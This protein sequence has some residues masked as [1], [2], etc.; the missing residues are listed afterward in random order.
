MSCAFLNSIYVIYLKNY[1]MEWSALLKY[2]NILHLLISQQA[3]YKYLISRNQNAAL[4]D[5]SFVH[6]QYVIQKN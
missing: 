1:L 5:Q 2:A 3:T 4:L 6:N